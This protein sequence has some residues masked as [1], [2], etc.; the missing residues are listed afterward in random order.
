MLLNVNRKGRVGRPTVSTAKIRNALQNL[1]DGQLGNIDSW[2]NQVANGTPKV[3][4]DGEPIRDNQGSLVFVVRP[5][6]ASAVK[7][8][9]D[10]A[11]YVV[12][13]LS[14]SDVAVVAKV[15]TVNDLNSMST[16]ELQHRLLVALGI[17]AEVVE[18]EKVPEFLQAERVES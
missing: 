15:E 12:P 13:K 7:I 4:Q 18:V 16:L 6:P 8:I 14:R 17:G 9:S 11:E 3:N 2:L 5:D 1:V 10:L